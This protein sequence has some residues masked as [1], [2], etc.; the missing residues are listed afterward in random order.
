MV[1]ELG[2]LDRAGCTRCRRARLFFHS[3]HATMQRTGFAR[4]SPGHMRRRTP[5]GSFGV[6]L[7]EDIEHLPQIS[8]RCSDIRRGAR[9]SIDPYR[10]YRAAINSPSPLVAT[11]TRTDAAT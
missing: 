7:A 3:I 9:L 11:P 5:H 8:P 6:E 2:D 4:A 10:G 1:V